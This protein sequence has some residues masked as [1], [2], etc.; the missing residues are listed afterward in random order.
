MVANTSNKRET[1]LLTEDKKIVV[2]TEVSRF[3]ENLYIS[4]FFVSNIGTQGIASIAL[5][6]S[7]ATEATANHNKLVELAKTLGFSGKEG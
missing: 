3:Q 5:K 4:V 7:S 6:S 2:S 1:I